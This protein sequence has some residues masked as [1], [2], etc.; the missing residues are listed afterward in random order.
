MPTDQCE[1]CDT[2]IDDD[3]MA[4]WMVCEDGK[5]V[6]GD[7]FRFCRFMCLKTWAIRSGDEP[8]KTYTTTPAFPKKARV[9]T[10]A[11]SDTSGA[12]DG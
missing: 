10:T 9:A 3:E 6:G 7:M 4:A 11:D 2:V 12:E 8:E 5:N 1:Y